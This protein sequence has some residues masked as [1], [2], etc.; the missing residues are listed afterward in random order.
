MNWEAI[1]AVGETIGAIAVVVT[2]VYLAAQVRSGNRALTT[3]VRDSA[4][5]QLQDWN[6]QLVADPELPFLFQRGTTDLE[7][8][9]EVERAR[10]VHVAFSFFKLFENLYMHHRDGSLAG[11]LW[12]GTKT[13]FQVYTQQPGLRV[14][15]DARRHFFNEDFAEM[16]DSL[17]PSPIMS[18]ADLIG[19]DSAVSAKGSAEQGTAADA[20]G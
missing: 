5:R 10:F 9:G 8:L 1:G 11:E 4:F 12:E 3:T 2:L 14:Y 13:V 16:V 19:L 17:E 20:L 6:T 18:G 7:S 15:W